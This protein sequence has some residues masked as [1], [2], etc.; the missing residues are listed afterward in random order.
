MTNA[1]FTLPSRQWKFESAAFF[2]GYWP[3]VYTSPGKLYTENR[4]YE[5]AL[6]TG[7]ICMGGKHFENGGD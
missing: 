3:T 6:K 1:M 2:Y 4:F 7:G 5:N